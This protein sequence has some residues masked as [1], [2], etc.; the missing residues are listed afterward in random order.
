VSA[1]RRIDLDPAE[2]A[3]WLAA[4]GFTDRLPVGLPTEEAVAAMVAASGRPADEPLGVMAPLP[5][6]VTVERLAVVAVLAGCPPEAF[7]VVVAAAQATMAPAFRLASVQSSTS[8]ASPL[9]VVNGAAR[10]AAGLSSGTGCFGPAAGANVAVGRAVRLALQVI[11]GGQPGTADPA[12]LGAPAKIAACF[13]EREEASPWPSLAERRG[14]LG[15]GDVGADGELPAVTG[16]ASV[17][18]VTGMWQIS[19]PSASPD[20]VVHQVLHGM[21]NTGHCA[22]PVLPEPGE[23]VLVLSPPIARAVASRFADLHDLQAALF[24]TVRVPLDWLPAYK[25]VATQERLEALGL[26]R[27]GLVPLAESPSCFVVLVA[28]GDAGVQSIALSTSPLCRSVTVG[29]R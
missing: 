21:I 9:V 18:A 7:P 23:Q 15:G 16:A 8:P 5:V 2:A 24:E 1:L 19:E 28:G 20:D 25:R 29:V 11:G 3:P 13:A 17:F 26:P 12:T 22:Q 27:D 4:H 6:E 10:E 14:V